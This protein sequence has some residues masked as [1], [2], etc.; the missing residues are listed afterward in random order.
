MFGSQF[1]QN[2]EVF[3]PLNSLADHFLTSYRSG[4]PGYRSS[5]TQG[6]QNTRKVSKHVNYYLVF[7]SK[8]LE[9]L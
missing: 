4:Q 8:G 2:W 7:T 6:R 3:L 9:W 1:V 5:L